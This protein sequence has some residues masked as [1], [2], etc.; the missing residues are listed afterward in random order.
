MKIAACYIRVSTED[1]VEYSPDAQLRAMKKYCSDNDLLLPKE[2]VFIDEGISGRSAKKRP[3]FQNMIKT[4]KIKPKPFDIILVHKFDRFARSREDSV[5]YKSMLRS[6]LGI[7]VVSVTEN[8]GDDKM[9]VIMESML[10]SMA[11]YYSLNLSDEVKKGMSEKAKKGGVQTKAS[12]G[13]RVENNKF[14]PDE[15]EAPYVKEIFE[16]FV[17]GEGYGSIARRMNARGIKTHRGNKFEQRTIRYII[18]NPVYIGTLRWTPSGKV[19]RNTP[20]SDTI[21]LENQHEPLVTREVWDAAQE[22]RNKLLLNS[23]KYLK[24]YSGVSYWLSGLLV[25]DNCGKTLSRA[26]KYLQCGGYSKSLCNVSHSIPIARAEELVINQLKEDYNNIMSVSLK[27]DGRKIKNTDE[28]KTYADAITRLEKSLQRAKDAYIAG[29]DTL[30]EYGENKTRIQDEIEKNKKLLKD[31]N[32]QK[33]TDPKELAENIMRAIEFIQDEN[34]SLED[35]NKALKQFISKI[36][37]IKAS[38]TLE[39]TYF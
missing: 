23:R 7:R 25:C 29:V 24:N 38:K 18:G 11:E 39:I 20:S 27:S 17:G 22:K 4:A 33:S 15:A 28:T 35:K 9:S 14:V 19:E 13:Y 6:E 34:N 26:G 31:Q 16:S 5:V 2:F 36:T 8:I 10:E 1:Q 3:A 12:F 30:E 21:F 37:F 32:T